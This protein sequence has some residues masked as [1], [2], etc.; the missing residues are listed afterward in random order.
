VRLLSV[1]PSA[2]PWPRTPED[3][4]F[5]NTESL[6]DAFVKLGNLAAAAETLRPTRALKHRS[7]LGPYWWMR[8]QLRLAEVYA[9][10]GQTGE[11]REIA[12]ELEQMLSEAEPDY[13]LLQRVG[14]LGATVRLAQGRAARL[15]TTR[16]N[17]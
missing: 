2:T 12:Y 11:A 14:M 16:A 9:E 13:P 8:C 6:A 5:R 3:D 10:L 7:I 15:M 4:F 17:A 1:T